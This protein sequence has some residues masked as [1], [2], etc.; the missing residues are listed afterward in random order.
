MEYTDAHSGMHIACPKCQHP[1]VLPAIPAGKLTTSLRLV[2]RVAKPAAKFRFTLP[3]IVLALRGFQHWKIVG[4]CLVPFVLVAGAFG[5]GIRLRP[6]PSGPAG[7]TRRGGGGPAG[8]G[9]VDGLDPRRPV[10]AGP[11]GGGQPRLRGLSSRRKETGGAAQPASRTGSLARRLSKGWTK[12][13]SGRIRPWPMPGK[14]SR[15]PSPITKSSAAPYPITEPIA[16]ILP[17]P[18]EGASVVIIAGIR[19]S[20][21]TPQTRETNLFMVPAD[22]HGGRVSPMASSSR[23]VR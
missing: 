9:H 23:R 12:P 4:M 2:R 21:R 3:G 16:L 17:G 11:V 1:I 22:G 5:G 13:P 20:S 7:S 15:Q 10:G 14:S 8:L 6:P 19:E 18:A